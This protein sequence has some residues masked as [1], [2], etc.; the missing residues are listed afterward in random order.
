MGLGFLFVLDDESAASHAGE[1]AVKSADTAAAA[2]SG[3]VADA[4]D[5]QQ[6]FI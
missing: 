6:C 2:S 3:A 4:P 5:G 1:R